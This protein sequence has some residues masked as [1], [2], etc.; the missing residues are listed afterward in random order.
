MDLDHV[1]FLA[2]ALSAFYVR[3]E[4]RHC[5]APALLRLVNDIREAVDRGEVSLLVLLDRS[6]AFDTINHSRAF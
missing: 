6:A 1:L 3:P 5:S 2:K 4:C